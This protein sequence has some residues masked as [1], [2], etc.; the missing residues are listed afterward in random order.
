MQQLVLGSWDVQSLVL[1]MRVAVAGK[2]Q[3]VERGRHCPVLSEPPLP[4]TLPITPLVKF[5]I[6]HQPKVVRVAPAKHIQ[7]RRVIC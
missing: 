7:L 1:G 3:R 5:N 6:V 4:I 2:H